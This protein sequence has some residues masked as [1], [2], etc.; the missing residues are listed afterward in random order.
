MKQYAIAAWLLLL[1]PA[2]PAANAADIPHVSGGIGEDEQKNLR[3]REGEFNLKLVFTLA[4]GNYLSDVSVTVEDAAKRRIIEHR[5][6]GPFFMAKLPAGQYRVAA[7]HEGRAVTR[8]VSVGGAGL[9]TEYLRWPSNPATD[10][11]L[12]REQSGQSGATASTKRGGG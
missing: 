11:P 9:R 8:N 5:A 3:A 6:S 7:V 1:L 4:E 10:F 2:Y 12:P